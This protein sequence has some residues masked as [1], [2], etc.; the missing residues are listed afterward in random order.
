[1]RTMMWMFC[2]LALAACAP[3]ISPQT[4]STVDRG[5]SFAQLKEAPEQQRGKVVLLGGAIA[6]VRNTER[7][8]ELEIVQLPTDDAGKP[9]GSA[10]SGGRF[11]AR[12]DRFLDPLVYQQGLLVTLVGE[13]AGKETRKIEQMEYIYPVLK[14]HE[15][16]LWEPEQLR[17]PR[18]HFGIGV[19]IGHRL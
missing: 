16:H 10:L 5:V 15:A 11:L 13:V 3:V 8:G 6:G 14:V 9:A 1:M 17:E 12:S 7:G 18:F 4:M 19:G 2:L